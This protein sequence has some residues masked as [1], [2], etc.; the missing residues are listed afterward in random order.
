MRASASSDGQT[1]RFDAARPFASERR[2]RFTEAEFWKTFATSGS[3]FT[4]FVPLANRC[5][6]LPRTPFE[7]SYSGRRSLRGFLRLVFFIVAAL[8]GGCEPSADK[9][10][11]ILLLFGVDYNHQLILCGD[12]E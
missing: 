3:S 6:Y 2:A 7:K 9:P 4:M 12:A 1:A 11:D 8:C 10:D 5:A